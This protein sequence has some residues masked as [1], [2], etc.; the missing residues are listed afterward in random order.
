MDCPHCGG[1]ERIGIH[2]HSERRFICHACGK[3]FSETKGTPLF[4][5]KY[6][7]WFVSV[8]LTLLAHGCP[9]KAIVSAFFLDERTVMDWLLKAGKHGK[10]I[11]EQTV[12]DGN[13]ELEQV[14]ADELCVTA[15]G[16]KVWMATAMVVKSRLFLGGV[17]S[18]CRDTA[19]IRRL[20][21]MVWQAGCN[22]FQPVLFAV[23]GLITYVGAIRKRFVTKVKTGKVGRPK[24]KIWPDLH[25]AQVV[26]CRDG[27]RIVDIQRRVVHGCKKRVKEIIVKTQGGTGKINTA[28]IERLNETFRS[29]MPSL[30]RRTR[31][32]ARTEQRLEYEMFWL[33]VVYNFH[34]VHGSLGETPTTKAGITD[35][36]WSIP[37][38][39]LFRPG[40]KRVHATL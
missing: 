10:T 12:C 2:S 3:T 7:I 23:D 35:R 26:K 17:V 13:V 34:S 16:G 28:F 20:I 9:A 14:Q 39:L 30:A 8:V 29:R 5:L 6:P 18:K 4:N 37:E 11:Q 40:V 32:L 19:L 27:G 25:I 24:H 31:N 1:G 33:G 15:Q 22:C 21:D 38:I 36:A